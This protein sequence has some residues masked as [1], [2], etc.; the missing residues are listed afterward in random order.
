MRGKGAN[1]PRLASEPHLHD[2][3]PGLAPG[4]RLDVVMRGVA[5][6]VAAVRSR[7]FERFGG[8]VLD[9]AG[10]PNRDG[11]ADPGRRAGRHDACRHVVVHPY[12]T[13]CRNHAILAHDRAVEHDGVTAHERTVFDRAVV[14]DRAV[15]DRD[16]VAD[17]GGP[18]ARCV[19][20]C[21]VLDGVRAPTRTVP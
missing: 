6:V 5:D 3:R 8:R 9:P 4:G 7:L 14:Q 2:D 21:V 10:V 16:V 1:S 20:D 18:S 17:D 11:L 15:T 19:D 12:D 13:A